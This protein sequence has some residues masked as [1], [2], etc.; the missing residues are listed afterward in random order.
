MLYKIFYLLLF[1]FSVQV[2]YSNI[3]SMDIVLKLNYWTMVNATKST[4][5]NETTK[6]VLHF[7]RVRRWWI[8]TSYMLNEFVTIIIIVKERIMKTIATKTDVNFRFW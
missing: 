1:I 7:K 2:S 4:R 8:P 6:V 5:V 3:T